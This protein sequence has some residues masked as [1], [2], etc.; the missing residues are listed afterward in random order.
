MQRKF[1]G[2]WPALVLSA[3]FLILS[4]GMAA[5]AALP[6]TYQEFKA[7]YQKEG[8]TPEGALKLYFEAVFCYLDPATRDEASKM[9][10]Y[11]LHYDMPIEQS[12]NLATFVERLK[13]PEY[14]HIF[15]GFAEGSS[16]ENDYRMSPD[17]FKLVVTKK[18]QEQ[19]YLR[20]FL[21]NSGADS[22]R[23][24][25]VKEYD[26]L[27]YTINN[28]STYVQVRPPKAEID[29]KKNAHDAD[30]DDPNTPKG[31]EDVSSSSGGG[32]AETSDSA[33]GGHSGEKDEGEFL[34][35]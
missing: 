13:Y 35:K 30:Y 8:R 14:H 23:P 16:P 3:V 25:W 32:G 4:C 31:P 28:S 33:N 22:P 27:W 2:R 24:V 11:A 9:V 7:R 21:R 12:Y 19:G 34:F 20:V 5:Q 29:R 1:F 6:K 26:G 17:N 18:T 15:R 10:R